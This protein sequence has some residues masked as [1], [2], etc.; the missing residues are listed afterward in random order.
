LSAHAAINKLAN[1]SDAAAFSRIFS[2]QTPEGLEIRKAC[3][4]CKNTPA[5]MMVTEPKYA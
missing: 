4:V 5:P 1:E 2:A 3:A